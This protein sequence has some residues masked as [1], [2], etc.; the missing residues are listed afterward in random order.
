MIIAHGPISYIS[1]EIIQ[2]KDLEKLNSREYLIYTVLA[3]LFGILVD[4]DIFVL[5]TTDIPAYQH[6]TVISHS[7]IFWIVLWILFYIFLRFVQGF[8]V[9]KIQDIL[10]ERFTRVLHRTFLIGVVSHLLMDLLVGHTILFYPILKQFTIL[11]D[12]FISNYFTGYAYAPGMGLEI[13]FICIFIFFIYKRFFRKNIFFEICMYFLSTISI[14]YLG[15]AIYMN[16]NTY[17]FSYQSNEMSIVYDGDYDTLS[18]ASD[19]DTDNDGINNIDEADMKEVLESTKKIVE[20]N[21]LAGYNR[22]RVLDTIKLKYGAFNSY[23]VI[24]QAYFNQN[25]AIEPVL[26]NEV[27]KN[28]YGYVLNYPKL[29]YQYLNDKRPLIE[30]TQSNTVIIPEGK[31]FFILDNQKDIENMGISLTGNRVI[32]VLKGDTRVQTHTY[33]DVINEYKDLDMIIVIQQ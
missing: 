9:S 22:E 28:S 4:F 17:N 15:F 19:P 6:H 1:N 23:R 21:V 10:N 18:D 25:M 16:L 13:V 33:Q 26:S 12:I 32:T 11:G 20:R 2:K 27:E 7:L 14:F 30:L 24:S 8:S 3:I 29:F 5:M 31:I